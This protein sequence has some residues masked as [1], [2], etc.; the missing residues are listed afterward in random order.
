MENN[1]VFARRIY[2]GAITVISYSANDHKTTVNKV[3][4]VIMEHPPCSSVGDR[5][6]QVVKYAL[7]MLSVLH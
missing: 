1:D 2:V 5:P 7:T 6:A 4:V 3:V